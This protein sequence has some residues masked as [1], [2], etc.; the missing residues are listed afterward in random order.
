MVDKL[1]QLS[2]GTFIKD[3]KLTQSSLVEDHIDW[4]G[5]YKEQL[6]NKYVTEVSLK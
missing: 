6:L 4:H 5:T 2:H 3:F 1:L